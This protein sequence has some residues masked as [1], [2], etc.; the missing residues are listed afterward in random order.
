ML[1]KGSV[2]DFSGCGLDPRGS[3]LLSRDLRGS[4]CF[5]AASMIVGISSASSYISSSGF[6]KTPLLEPLLTW[7][8][9]L[10]LRAPFC[11]MFSCSTTATGDS[12]TGTASIAVVDGGA[13]AGAGAGVGAD[14]AGSGFGRLLSHGSRCLLLSVEAVESP[15]AERELVL[16]SIPIDCEGFLAWPSSP[17]FG[18]SFS[19]S[20]F[21]YAEVFSTSASCGF[22]CFQT[23]SA[24]SILAASCILISSSFLSIFCRA[25]RKACASS[26]SL[27]LADD[28]W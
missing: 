15:D 20:G 24:A 23:K 3:E 22:R 17:Y 28:S 27:T 6:L 5:E 19:R 21:G 14:T 11:K 16:V 18:L 2:K 1:G 4:C 8:F 10:V 7:R 25:S 9:P 26:L 13:G 12:T